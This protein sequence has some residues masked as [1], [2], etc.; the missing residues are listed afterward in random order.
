MTLNAIPNNMEK[1]MAI[2]LGRNL[3]FI[4]S[5][6]F[7]SQSLEKL[8]DNLPKEDFKYT[9]EISKDKTLEVISQKGVYPYDYM[10]S[11]EKFNPTA[12]PSKE[13]LYS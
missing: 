13:Q 9:S 10:D 2:M 3:V 5:F 8:V 4:D 7:M 11:F 1:Y 12:F 6:Q